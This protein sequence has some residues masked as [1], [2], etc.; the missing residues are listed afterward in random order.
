MN[1]QER[2]ALVVG[3]GRGVGRA[4]ATA[5]AASHAK[6]IGVA[7]TR[8]DLEARTIT[9]DSLS[10]RQVLRMVQR[11]VPRRAVVRRNPL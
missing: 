1:I 10:S 2:T 9:A 11:S 6:V 3:A 4:V 8:A 5:L 7:R